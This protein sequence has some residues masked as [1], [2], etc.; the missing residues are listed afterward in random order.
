MILWFKYICTLSDLIFYANVANIQLDQVV[1]GEQEKVSDKGE[2]EDDN[3][4]GGLGGCGG[5]GV[6]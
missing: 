1:L 6:G 4:K 2:K 3:N 5:C